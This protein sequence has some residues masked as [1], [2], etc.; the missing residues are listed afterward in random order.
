MID[1]I[2]RL[3]VGQPV[4]GQDVATPNGQEAEVNHVEE[5]RQPTRERGNQ[6]DD[7]NEQELEAPNHSAT[8]PSLRPDRA[9]GATFTVSSPSRVG[10]SYAASVRAGALGL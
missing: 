5:E 6:E 4:S 10:G 9:A 2:A 7:R 3:Q 1:A 8:V